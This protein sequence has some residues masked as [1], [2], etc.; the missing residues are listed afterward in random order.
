MPKTTS[1]NIERNKLRKHSTK[2]TSYNFS[3]C[4]YFPI[5][6][7]RP[8]G[9][10][11]LSSFNVSAVSLFLCLT[12]SSSIVVFASNNLYDVLNL[13][14]GN[15]RCKMLNNGELLTVTLDKVSGSGFESKYEYL[16]A[17]IDMQ[18]K[19][20]AGNSAGTVT[21]FFVSLPKLL[22]LFLNCNNVKY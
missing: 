1:D 22:Q 10:A 11:A 13:S 19:L 5:M 8:L 20:V 17:R 2:S 16:Y 6:K 18:I 12:F 15:G 21:A 3:L 14:W 4:F 7:N 9:S